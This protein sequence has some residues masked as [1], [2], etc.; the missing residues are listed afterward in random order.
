[1]ARLGGVGNSGLDEP[2]RSLIDLK[3]WWLELI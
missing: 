1:M 3:M 2:A